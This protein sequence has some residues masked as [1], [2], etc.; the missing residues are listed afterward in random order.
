M[1]LSCSR[2]PKF[3]LISQSNF[4]HIQKLPL[5]K[6]CFLTMELFIFLSKHYARIF[7]TFLQRMLFSFKKTDYKH[8]ERTGLSDKNKFTVYTLV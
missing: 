3:S 7:H 1:L 5:L 8:V 6:M 2:F 4:L